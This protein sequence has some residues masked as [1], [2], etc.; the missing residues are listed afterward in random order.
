MC[1][2]NPD[3]RPHR[4]FSEGYKSVLKKDGRYFSYDYIPASGK[5]EY[6]KD[7]WVHDPKAGETSNN[8]YPTGFHIALELRYLQG[9]M[10]DDEDHAIIKVK[11]KNVVA[12][13]C[14][15]VD[16][17]YG[18]QVVALDIMVLEEIE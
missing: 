12:S 16:S 15:S 17:I 5:I 18:P 3:Q 9:G 10:F 6:L 14:E 1:I 7:V 8:G 13:K 4:E 2:Y 11:F